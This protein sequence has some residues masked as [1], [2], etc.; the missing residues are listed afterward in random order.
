MGI[1]KSV[2][3]SD[4][5]ADK[6]ASLYNNEWSY[7]VNHQFD[8]AEEMETVIRRLAVQLLPDLPIDAWQYVLNAFRLRIPIR[9]YELQNPR[10]AN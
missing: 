1:K 8:K 2:M 4:K 9:G 5:N 3:I 10:I 6:V 7:A